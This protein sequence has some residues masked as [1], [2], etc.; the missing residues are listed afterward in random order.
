LPYLPCLAPARRRHLRQ[1]SI[2]NYL[3]RDASQLLA[4]CVFQDKENYA[5][6]TLCIIKEFSEVL[7]N[8]E[9]QQP[10]VVRIRSA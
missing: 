6:N 9:R 5:D 4:G 8:A 2:K 3:L 10:A 7:G 1:K